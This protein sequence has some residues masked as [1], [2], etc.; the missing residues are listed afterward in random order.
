MSDSGRGGTG[1]HHVRRQEYPLIL[2]NLTLLLAAVV[3]YGRLVIA[4]ENGNC[5]DRT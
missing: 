1:T 5:G 3:L 4:R 2:I